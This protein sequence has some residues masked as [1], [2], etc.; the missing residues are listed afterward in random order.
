MDAIIRSR[1]PKLFA[2]LSGMMGSLVI[3]KGHCHC[4]RQPSYGSEK[5]RGTSSAGMLLNSQGCVISARLMRGF[6]TLLKMKSPLS[7][8][9]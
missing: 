1:R 2:D 7:F 9:S 5:S 3:V 8:N 4:E 6:A